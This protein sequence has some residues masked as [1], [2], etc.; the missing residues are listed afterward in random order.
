MITSVAVR[1]GV[2]SGRANGPSLR[3]S[4]LALLLLGISYRPGVR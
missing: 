2:L 3:L 4:L 1:V